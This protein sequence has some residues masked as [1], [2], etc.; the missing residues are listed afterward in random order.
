MPQRVAPSM[1]H[2]TMVPGPEDMDGACACANAVTEQTNASRSP[3]NP[4]TLEWPS[5]RIIANL[6]LGDTESR[7]FVSKNRIAIVDTFQTPRGFPW[8]RRAGAGS[9]DCQIA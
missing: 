5:A 7:R 1:V 4:T 2:L 6:H 3:L 9:K 8:P